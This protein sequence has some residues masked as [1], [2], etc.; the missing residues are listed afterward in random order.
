MKKSGFRWWLGLIGL[1]LILIAALPARAAPPGSAR[2]LPF[3][4]SS[5][6]AEP[7]LTLLSSDA[8]AIALET[9][10]PGCL[11]EEVRV[12]GQVYTRLYGQGYGHPAAVGRPDLPV[13]RREVEIPFGATVAVEL[14]QAEYTDYTLADLDLHPIYPLQP[15]L[16]KV[17]GAEDRPLTV[18]RTF[19]DS[20][21]RYP[22]SP[23]ALGETYIV[24]GHRVQTVEVWPVA[25]DPAAGTVRLYSRITFRLPLSRSRKVIR[26]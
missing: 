11:A 16:P 5:T 1:S 10:L 2:W 17:A 24:R 4:G 8:T 14:I 26:E 6:P 3:D 9:G 25:Y 12:E 22:A 23:L 13:L 19:Y 20:G 18:D 7:T 15:P 21:T